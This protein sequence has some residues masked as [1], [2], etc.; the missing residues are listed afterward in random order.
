MR[1]GC[2]RLVIAPRTVIG[3][4]GARGAHRLPTPAAGSALTRD[5]SKLRT[6]DE[7]R[8][9]ARSECLVRD[10]IQ[11]A[12][13]EEADRQSP[14]SLPLN[15]WNEIRHPDVERHARRE[16]QAILPEDW[17]GLSQDRAEQSRDRERDTRTEC[18]APALARG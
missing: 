11:R 7:F 14:L 15:L 17:N 18:G 1:C 6:E 5:N 8:S 4:E 3:R 16:R 9:L 10:V 2:G 13:N 12:A